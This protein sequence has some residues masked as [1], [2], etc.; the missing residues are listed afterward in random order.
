MT[1]MSNVYV[2]GWKRDSWFEWNS[3]TSGMHW[4]KRHEGNNAMSSL[5]ETFCEF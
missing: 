5:I 1:F 3:R 4:E 2:S